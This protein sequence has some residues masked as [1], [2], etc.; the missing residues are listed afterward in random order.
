M[1]NTNILATIAI[2]IICKVQTTPCG[3]NCDLITPAPVLQSTLH[4]N[5]PKVN[6]GLLNYSPRLIPACSCP[7]QASCCLKPFPLNT[8]PGSLSVKPSP[9]STEAILTCPTSDSHY[10]STPCSI[11]S[12]KTSCISPVTVNTSPINPAPLSSAEVL[13]LISRL[14][15][16]QP[17]SETTPILKPVPVTDIATEQVQVP[18]ATCLP[19]LTVPSNLVSEPCL[20]Q[21]PALEPYTT[22]DSN[23]K[24]TSVSTV[25]SKQIPLTSSCPALTSVT[26]TTPTSIVAPT[27][28]LIITPVPATI[29]APT[30][31]KVS[32]SASSCNKIPTSVVE[33][34]RTPI[35]T[36]KSNLPPVITAPKI[37]SISVDNTVSTSVPIP[38]ANYASLSSE[39][40]LKLLSLLPSTPNSCSSPIPIIEP[41]Q[42]SAVVSTP[43]PISKVAAAPCPAP[44]VAPEQV[45][46]TIEAT[47]PCS[48]PIVTP[49]PIPIS[50][51]AAPPCL[52]PAATS[53]PIPIISSTPMP[54]KYST[55]CSSSTFAQVPATTSIS[56]SAILNLLT[57]LSTTQQNSIQAPATA[58]VPTQIVSSVLSPVSTPSI[59]PTSIPNA[60]PTLAPVVTSTSAPAIPSSPYSP[61]AILNL[62]SF[63]TLIQRSPIPPPITI[64]DTLSSPTSVPPSSI[65]PPVS[66]V[67]QITSTPTPSSLSR[68]LTL[69][70]TLVSQPNFTPCATTGYYS[71]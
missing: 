24:P 19:A 4:C 34:I 39:E 68:V 36:S 48:A 2:T 25:T 18:A 11:P 22:S 23:L 46:K 58:S 6:K 49:A 5:G 65:L 70:S 69:L 47:V 55:P 43:A 50:E 59:T 37:Y 8:K 71:K 42:T 40:I 51:V 10:S 20:A 35:S 15:A 44:I 38:T 12:T 9:L 63:L 33:D 27:S 56:P 28:S 53:A 61:S 32:A 26:A 62:L 64:P 66:Y 3:F 30:E 45:S 52:A 41:L 57:L 17:L 21:I 60:S 13:N 67:S 29:T 16:V 14:T 31:V 1:I 7:L 54:A